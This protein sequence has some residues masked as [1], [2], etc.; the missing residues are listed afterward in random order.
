MLGYKFDRRLCAVCKQ[1]DKGK[2]IY[3]MLC[4]PAPCW[5]CRRRLLAADGDTQKV[6]Y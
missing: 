6:D 4:L 3:V 2:K 1:T 5:C